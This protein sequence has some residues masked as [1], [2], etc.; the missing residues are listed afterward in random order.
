MK[1]NDDVLSDD[2]CSLQNVCGKYI[3][4][5]YMMHNV[6]LIRLVDHN[7]NLYKL[8]GQFM[9]TNSARHLHVLLA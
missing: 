8:P 3:C 7:I 2:V 6:Q 4:C 1:L 5:L 9:V